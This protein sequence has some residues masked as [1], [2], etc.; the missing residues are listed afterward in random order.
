M[1]TTLFEF[2]SLNVRK[3]LGLGAMTLALA[4]LP[5]CSDDDI[6]NG[7]GDEPI[8]DNSIVGGVDVT[9]KQDPSLAMTYRMSQNSKLP[10]INGA[11][12]EAPSKKELAEMFQLPANWTGGYI[13]IELSEAIPESEFVAPK[14]SPKVYVPKGTYQNLPSTITI[15]YKSPYKYVD[16]PN[17][18]K[19][20]TKNVPITVEAYYIDSE[21][22]F[23]GIG[24]E[25]AKME[26]HI[27]KGGV[28]SCNQNI[29]EATTVYLYKGGVLKKAQNGNNEI[30]V[31]G[32]LKSDADIEVSNTKITLQGDFYTTGKITAQEIKLLG[33]EMYAGCAI[34][35][36][37]KLYITGTNSHLSAGY[38]ASPQ[39]ELAGGDNN[40]K[41]YITLRD[42]GYLWAKGKD[43]KLILHN[44]NNIEISAED[45]G[46]ALVETSILEAN[47]WDLTNTFDNV[48]IKYSKFTGTQEKDKPQFNENCPQNNDVKYEVVESDFCAPYEIVD[49][50][51]E[52]EEPVGPTIENVGSIDGPAT[53]DHKISATCI[54][55]HDN[56]DAYISW[57]T[58]GD[59][60]HGC[61]EHAT[62]KDN[63][64]TLKAYLETSVSNEAYGKVDFNHVIYDNGKLFVT[65]DHPEKG[66]IVGW[67]DCE[68]G[69]F[70]TANGAKLNLRQLYS[71]GYKTGEKDDKGK[72]VIKYSNGG[73][74]NCII[75]NG[76]YYQIASVAGFETFNYNDFIADTKFK[77]V[78]NLDAWKFN[79][80]ASESL[81][82]WKRDGRNTG[83]HIATDG[84][85]VVMLTLI[86]RDNG[87]NTATASLRVYSADDVK[88][89]TPIASCVINN[90]I[91][92][93]VNGKNVVAIEGDNIWVCLGNGGVKHLKINGSSII[94]QSSF[95][96]KDKS[97]E[98]LKKL[99]LTEKEAAAACA[100][101][102]AVDENYIYVAHGGAGIVLLDKNDLSYVT[103]TKNHSGSANYVA[104]AN[105]Y[106]YVAYGLSKV[107]VYR[108]K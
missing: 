25:D 12:P 13:G 97:K 17:D 54:Y 14:I 61:I 38:I 21:V 108:L 7:G 76:E 65:G 32:T 41:L 74:G 5:A 71:Y 47:N 28:V 51:D 27:L 34:E 93:P 4:I 53:H 96:I 6:A 89:T 35:A 52:S 50:N 73:S 10:S 45:G 18:I 31:K 62:V 22:T 40:E 20:W 87:T 46:A 30:F 70:P 16:G 43:G 42:K 92:S 19:N 48:A 55:V 11:M 107:Q 68:S 90:A 15:Q 57:H 106:I 99:G 58:Q 94:E 60:F 9:V 81:T 29:A 2:H 98:E 39:I 33:G 36:T 95:C 101:G 88:Y 104:L 63:I 103:R 69:S 83:K 8:P 37:D 85:S 105:D 49:P 24:N 44:F 75:R 77:P 64:V 102:L 26:Y 100:N 59:E 82:P 67:I 84:Q 79:P 23:G 3:V 78:A 91:L 56:N 1:K 86:D 80:S 72:D 66:G